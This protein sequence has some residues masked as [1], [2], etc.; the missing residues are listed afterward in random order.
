MPAW[1]HDAALRGRYSEWP[2]WVDSGADGEAAPIL[3]VRGIAKDLRGANVA[4]ICT[5]AVHRLTSQRW[6]AASATW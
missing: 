6:P 5:G 2:R 4:D 1:L 3:A